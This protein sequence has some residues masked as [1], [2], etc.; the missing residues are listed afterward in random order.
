MDMGGAARTA[1]GRL[2]RQWR[3][4]LE[5]S[6]AASIAFLISYRV[7]GHP[8]PFFAPASAVIVLGAA[9]GER[10]GRAVE[11]LLGVAFGVLAADVVAAWLGPGT[12]VTV[13]VVIALTSTVAVLLGG[14]GILL[15]QA[16][17]SSAGEPPSQSPGCSV[18]ATRWGRPCARR[19]RSTTSSPRSCGRWSTRWRRPTRTRRSRR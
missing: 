12:T 10:R 11:V 18:R 9:R 13:L 17:V 19:S 14:S 2:R 3:F 7:L 1:A 4:V 6:L 15:V 8:Q 16:L 5:A